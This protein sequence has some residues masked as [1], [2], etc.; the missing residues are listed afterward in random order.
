MKQEVK[1]VINEAIVYL[2]INKKIAI[3]D[4]R[5]DAT[6]LLA[7]ILKKNVS[8]LLL[9]ESY[10]V[11]ANYLKQFKKQLA[12]LQ[13]GEPLQYIIKEWDFMGRRFFCNKSALIPRPATEQLVEWVIK[14]IKQHNKKENITL[15]DV[16]TGSGIIAITLALE[17]TNAKIVATDISQEALALA[18]KNAALH[19]V[20][21]K[22]IFKKK[23][24]LANEPALYFDFIVANLPYI[25]AEEMDNLPDSVKMFEPHSALNGGRGGIDLINQLI[26]QAVCVLKRGGVLFLECSL[27]QKERVQGS[28]TSSNFKNIIS[29]KDYSGTIAFIGAQR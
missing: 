9:N 28:L 21:N 11:P 15:A 29:C 19:K 4:A 14:Y 22:I 27:R 24:L 20:Q 17:L 26:K 5:R 6:F 25:P 7:H 12:R 16:G 8:Q 23:N 1:N 10:K 3:D 13:A 18:K 2:T